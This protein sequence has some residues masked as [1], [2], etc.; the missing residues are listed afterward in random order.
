M[1]GALGGSILRVALGKKLAYEIHNGGCWID[2]EG[3][4]DVWQAAL[5]EFV[6]TFILLSATF[7]FLIG[8]GHPNRIVARS[9]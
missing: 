6:S 4:V 7:P 9:S 3:E 2:S 8:L 5:I 1:G